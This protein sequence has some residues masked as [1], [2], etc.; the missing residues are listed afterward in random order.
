M[1][2][3]YNPNAYPYQ[4]NE[5]ELPSNQTAAAAY[6]ALP[7]ASQSGAWGGPTV[8]TQWAQSPYYL[9]NWGDESQAPGTAASQA[10]SPVSTA[11]VTR[12]DAVINARDLSAN[13]ALNTQKASL[14]ATQTTI[15]NQIAAINAITTAD[16]TVVQVSPATAV[17]GTATLVTIQGSGFTGATAVNIGGACTGVTVVDD[18]E[19][20]ATTPTTS[21]AGTVNVTVTSPAGTGTLT[22]GFVY[23]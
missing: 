14:T 9:P 7:Y 22:N 2:T 4:L 23:T 3:P 6:L 20:T 16:A 10:T 5:K 21:V 1:A 8:G 11:S 12:P 13:T 19:L 15:T 18:G 17:H